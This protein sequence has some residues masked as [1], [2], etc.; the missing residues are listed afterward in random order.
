MAKEHEAQAAT[1][2][3]LAALGDAKEAAA[4]AAGELTLARAAEKRSVDA[5]AK[6]EAANAAAVGEG[7]RRFIEQSAHYDV[8]LVRDFTSTRKLARP[9]WLPALH[10]VR[11]E[12][13]ADQRIL[14][15]AIDVDP[16]AI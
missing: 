16:L 6:S 12:R 3:A 7:L 4:R 10:T 1:Q 5:L 8:R 14:R 2:R 9:D 13:V 11:R 15:W